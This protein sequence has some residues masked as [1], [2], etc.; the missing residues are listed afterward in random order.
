LNFFIVI[1]KY[2]VNR[3]NSRQQ[4]VQQEQQECEYWRQPEPRIA[5]EKEVSRPILFQCVQYTHCECDHRSQI[6]VGSWFIRWEFLMEGREHHDIRT[7]A[8]LLRLAG[9]VWGIQKS[10]TRPWGKTSMASIAAATW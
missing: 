8:I 6:S 10:Q 7:Q 5:W 9:A 4:N 2:A 1:Y 3:S